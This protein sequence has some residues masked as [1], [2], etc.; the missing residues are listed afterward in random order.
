MKNKSPLKKQFTIS[1]SQQDRDSLFAAA[2]KSGQSVCKFVRIAVN[3]KLRMLGYL[4][5]HENA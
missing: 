2:E 3:E 1:F 4:T 5:E